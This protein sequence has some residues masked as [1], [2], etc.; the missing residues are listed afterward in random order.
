ML[1]VLFAVVANECEA[2]GDGVTYGGTCDCIGGIE[3]GAGGAAACISAGT[4][5]GCAGTGVW[6]LEFDSCR[7]GITSWG[8]VIPELIAWATNSAL[9]FSNSSGGTCKLK[10]I[11]KRKSTSRPFISLTNT[12][13][14]F[15]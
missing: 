4:A 12:P 9:Y 3:V 15:E 7:S 14:T 2:C 1:V 5:A 13:P 8:I 11:R 6:L 10:L